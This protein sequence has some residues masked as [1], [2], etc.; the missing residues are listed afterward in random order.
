M[1][2]NMNNGGRWHHIASEREV[3]R[4]LADKH[5]EIIECPGINMTFMVSK[6][7]QTILRCGAGGGDI[8]N[9]EG[10]WVYKSTIPML[11]DREELYT[12]ARVPGPER[13]S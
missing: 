10:G 9:V 4:A 11:L 2:P 7:R 3:R 8:F 6:A 1:Q 5:S 13:V 12:L